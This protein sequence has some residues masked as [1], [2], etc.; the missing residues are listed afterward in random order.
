MGNYKNTWSGDFKEKLKP[1]HIESINL[2]MGGLTEEEMNEILPLIR[3]AD[4]H[5]V[6]DKSNFSAYY[7]SMEI[8]FSDGSSETIEDHGTHFEIK[9]RRVKETTY[10]FSSEELK[11]WIREHEK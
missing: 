7:T 6:T 11:R 5:Y 3:N 10:I 1:E 8:N 4:M 2:G 9:P